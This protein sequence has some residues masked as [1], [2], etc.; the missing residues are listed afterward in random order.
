MLVYTA[1]RLELTACRYRIVLQ[2]GQPV[3]M[4]MLDKSSYDFGD[5]SPS[6][7]WLCL[8]IPSP[9]S[10]SV[11]IAQPRSVSELSGE[12]QCGLIVMNIR[13]QRMV[14]IQ[15]ASAAWHVLATSAVLNA[16]VATLCVAVFSAVREVG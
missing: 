2:S 6:R 8:S 15:T 1:L 16:T 5:G 14:P 9:Y 11:H 10:F 12:R 3:S 7:H 4:Q 13:E